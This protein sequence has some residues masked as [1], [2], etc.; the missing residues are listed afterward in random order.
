MCPFGMF[1]SITITIYV[2]KKG[3][4]DGDIFFLES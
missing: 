4:F 1:F 2:E 3:S